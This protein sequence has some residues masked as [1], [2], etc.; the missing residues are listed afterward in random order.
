MFI[1]SN[2]VFI[3]VIIMENKKA[4]DVT[5]KGWSKANINKLKDKL[6]Q[7]GMKF[8]VQVKLKDGTT[9]YLY[10]ID[11]NDVK[12]YCEQVGAKIVKIE[13]FD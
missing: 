11:P 7:N 8:Q 9:K 13:D 1:K 12:P 6:I 10:V 4:L 2:S 5:T 3:L